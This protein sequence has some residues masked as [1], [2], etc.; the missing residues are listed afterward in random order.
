[1]AS[2]TS[3][4]TYACNVCKHK[5]GFENIRYG[6][7][8]KSMVCTDCYNK[9]TK[10]QKNKKYEPSSL[11]EKIKRDK[12]GQPTNNSGIIKVICV[13]CRYKFSLNRNSRVNQ[14]CPYCSGSN[15]TSDNTTA[16]KI[17][18]EVSKMKDNKLNQKFL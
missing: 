6:Y 13:D 7:D 12:G 9:V 15:L 2:N 5:V 18:D 10:D 3:S 16:D 8:G 1:M 11:R 14:I 17:V 4:S